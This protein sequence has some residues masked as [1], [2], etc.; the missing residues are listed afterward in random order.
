[1]APQIP[2]TLWATSFAAG[3]I[4]FFSPCTLPL[5][6]AYLS[7]LTGV[8]EYADLV[9]ESSR[10]KILPHALLF[11]AGFT[12]VFVALGAS[13]TALGAAVSE[14]QRAFELLGGLLITAFGLSMIGLLR[15]PALYRD[16]R[17]R[18][19]ARPAG[20]AGSMLIGAAFAAGWSPCVG[21]ILAFILALAAQT[22]SV[23]QGMLLLS[24]YSLGLGIPFVLCSLGL[25]RFMSWMH[26]KGHWLG[27]LELAAGLLLAAVGVAMLAGWWGRLSSM[28][29]AWSYK[30][31]L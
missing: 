26:G 29:L 31:M 7:Y 11:V 2:A 19:K 12:A 6:P 25:E 16:L 3:L 17:W 28:L 15:I 5:L 1:M 13:A 27:R 18:P 30:P 21:P 9:H 22:H 14:H 10:H 23:G 24:V 8:E 20:L 4:S